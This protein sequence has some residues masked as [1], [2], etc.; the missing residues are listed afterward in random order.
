MWDYG[1][2]SA[3][4]MLVISQTCVAPD[5][6]LVTDGRQDDLIAAFKEVY[7][8]FYPEGPAS[9][10]SFS[11]II[12]ERHFDRIH[13]MLSDTKGQ[14]VLGG[15]AKRES[16]YIAPTIVRDVE[17]ED[18]LMSAYVYTSPLCPLRLEGECSLAFHFSE[19]FGPVLPILAVPDVQAAVDFVNER[20]RP[21]ALYLFSNDSKNKQFGEL[22]SERDNGHI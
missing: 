6:I 1:T 13:K 3:L 8:Q 10:E 18:S 19:I 21:L 16:K 7:A 9:P 4:D 17:N 11:R 22:I 14:V 12:A 15:E 2:L 5:Y 20:D